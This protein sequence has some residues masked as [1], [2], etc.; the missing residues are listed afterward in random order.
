M[1]YFFLRSSVINALL[2]IVNGL[3]DRNHAFPNLLLGHECNDRNEDDVEEAHTILDQQE[4]EVVVQVQLCKVH[5]KWVG[6]QKDNGEGDNDWPAGSLFAQ[7]LVLLLVPTTLTSR[8]LSTGANKP[9]KHRKD[10]LSEKKNNNVQ[11]DFQLGRNSTQEATPDL[12]SASM[13]PNRG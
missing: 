13:A 8:R 3:K 11:T 7:F 1:L 6:G 12:F 2:W 9:A 5:V 10:A 4:G